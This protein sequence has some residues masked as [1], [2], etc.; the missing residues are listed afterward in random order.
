MVRPPQEAPRRRRT[1][2]GDAGVGAALAGLGTA[3]LAH[4]V[5]AE[6]VV[7]VLL[8][9]AAALGGLVLLVASLRLLPDG[10]APAG[11]TGGAVLL[12]VGTVLLRHPLL[13]LGTVT[14]VAGAAF[15]VA[16]AARLAAARSA[17][18]LVPGA[19]TL[20]FGLLL[21]VEVPGSSREFVGVVL[22]VQLLVDGGVLLGA[23]RRR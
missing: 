9:V 2:A 23:R 16:G 3:V 19:V 14:L 22:G 7:L 17:R 15:L 6:V 1:G 5:L 8:G 18:A 12:V 21:L 11:V 13:A 4:V 20:L 10:I